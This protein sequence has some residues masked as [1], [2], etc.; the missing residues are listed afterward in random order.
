MSKRATRP[1]NHAVTVGPRIIPVDVHGCD[2]LPKVRERLRTLATGV[3]AW[4]ILGGTVFHTAGG[5]ELRFTVT[6]DG[7]ALTPGQVHCLVESIRLQ[8][9]GTTVAVWVGGAETHSVVRAF[10]SN[11]RRRGA[12]PLDI[13]SMN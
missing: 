11:D 2:A 5:S 10:I 3:M 6:A 1:R 8:S 4:H 7:R 12:F 13:P 9:G